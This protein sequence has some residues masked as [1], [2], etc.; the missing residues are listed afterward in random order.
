MKINFKCNKCKKNFDCDVGKISL[1][2]KTMR[3]NFS[4]SIEC[5][6]CGK[7]TIDEVTLTELGQSQLTEATFGL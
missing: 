3:P 2:E 1:N 7:R 4:K 5:P 6:R